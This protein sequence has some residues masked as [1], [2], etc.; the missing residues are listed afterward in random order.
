MQAAAFMLMKKIKICSDPGCPVCC[1]ISDLLK[2]VQDFIKSPEYSQDNVI[3]TL[4]DRSLGWCACTR[5]EFG[6]DPNTCNNHTT[7]IPAANYSQAKYYKPRE[8]YD[9]M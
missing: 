7:G 4:F 2:R 8:V 5:E 6:F 9:E 1:T 3:S